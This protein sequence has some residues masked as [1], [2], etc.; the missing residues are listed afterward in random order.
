MITHPAPRYRSS[1]EIQGSSM[2]FIPPGRLNRS[3]WMFFGPYHVFLIER[4]NPQG[5]KTFRRFGNP[6]GPGKRFVSSYGWTWTSDCWIRSSVTDCS[7]YKVVYVVR[8]P[9][10]VL[11]LR[12]RPSSKSIDWAWRITELS[13]TFTREGI[14]WPA[15]WWI[16]YVLPKRKQP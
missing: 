5:I 11:N 1:M 4:S 12:W 3:E 8:H 15:S 16:R 14:G 2:G 9:W 7:A 13:P 6:L 10:L